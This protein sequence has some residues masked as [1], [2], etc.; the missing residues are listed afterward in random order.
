MSLDLFAPLVQEEDN[1]STSRDRPEPPDFPKIDADP[2]SLDFGARETALKQ[3]V[4]GLEACPVCGAPLQMLEHAD[5]RVRRVNN[6]PDY[7][8]GLMR[9]Y[10]QVVAKFSCGFLISAISDGGIVCR[11]PCLTGSSNAI[12]SLWDKT[13][14]LDRRA[15]APGDGA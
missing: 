1:G 15:A 11:W 5:G 3:T 14:G 4:A 13:F 9:G 12:L 8:E 7:P 10:D 6:F 2:A